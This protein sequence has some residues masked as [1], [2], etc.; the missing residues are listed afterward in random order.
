MKVKNR[1]AYARL[2][3]VVKESLFEEVSS[4]VAT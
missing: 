2:S 1:E 4:E 3:R